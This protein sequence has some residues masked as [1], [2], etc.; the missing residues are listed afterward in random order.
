MNKK[1][2]FLVIEGNVK[3][4]NDLI[5]FIAQKKNDTEDELLDNYMVSSVRSNIYF[6]SGIIEFNAKIGNEHDK[7]QLN[8]GS[9]K[10]GFLNLGLNPKNHAYGIAENV[11]GK[12][13]NIYMTG[14][15]NSAPI[16]EWLKVKIKCFGSNIELFVNDVLVGNAQKNLH[17]AQVNI[18]YK[19]MKKAL[20]KDF[21]VS[22]IRPKAFIVMQFSDS[23]NALYKEVL[24]PICEEFGYDVV[25]ADD[26]HTT[27]LIINDITEAIKESSLVIADMTPDNPNVFYEIGYSHAINKPTIL[28]SDKK[29]DKLPFDISSFRVLFY[30]NSIAGKSNVEESLRKH[31]EAIK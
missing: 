29:R 1:V 30:D 23:Y 31:L 6:N 10:N 20:I 28:L 16:N 4:Q 27:N 8:I 24:K 11:N 17:L 2:D 25:R 18:T 12:F 13:T 5:E 3:L 7:L 19:G 21:K 22:A 15:G 26:M 14:R 9:N